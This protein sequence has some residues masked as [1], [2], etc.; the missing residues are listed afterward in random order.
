MEKAV[1]EADGMQ[2]PLPKNEE[3]ERGWL[4][5]CCKKAH[6]RTLA[7][8]TFGSRPQHC[9]SFDTMMKNLEY[10]IEQIHQKLCTMAQ[11]NFASH[12][13]EGR[14]LFFLERKWH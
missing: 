5:K 8:C 13:K 1:E 7:A 14:Q 10:N 11:V 12:Q 3:R 6:A 4:R 9:R 2:C